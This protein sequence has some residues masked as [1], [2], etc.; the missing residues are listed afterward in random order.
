MPSLHSRRE[1][2]GASTVAVGVTLLAGVPGPA[3]AS[4]QPVRVFVWDELQPA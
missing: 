3:G 1:F 4:N 2:L